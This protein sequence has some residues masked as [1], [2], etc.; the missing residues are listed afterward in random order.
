M[1]LKSVRQTVDLRFFVPMLWQ[2]QPRLCTQTYT[3]AH[4]HSHIHIHTQSHCRPKYK[5]IPHQFKSTYFCVSPREI[6]TIE[7]T[8]FQIQLLQMT[9]NGS[10]DGIISHL[11]T[12]TRFYIPMVLCHYKQKYQMVN[13]QELKDAL[14]NF[15]VHFLS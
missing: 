6:K 13:T 9:Q 3:H 2:V 11:R 12:M 5:D 10:H 1:L 14:K 8:L 7:Q 15:Y 4:R